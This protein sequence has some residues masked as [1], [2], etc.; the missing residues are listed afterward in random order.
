MLDGITENITNTLCKSGLIQNVDREIYR[1][2]IETAL[3]KSLHLFTMLIIGFAFRMP[4]EAI[5]FVIAYSSIRIYAGGFHAKTKVQ[6][7]ILSC[8]M[9]TGALLFDSYL[10]QKF[11]NQLS[12]ALTIVSICLILWL[13]PVANINKPLDQAEICHYKKCVVIIVFIHVVALLVF[14]IANLYRF[15][16]IISISECFLAAMLVIGKLQLDHLMKVR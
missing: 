12:W 13:S 9:I 5:L 4:L 11:M 1:F 3:L 8:L 15:Q 16:L 6:C 10:P 2:G 7:Y 14:S